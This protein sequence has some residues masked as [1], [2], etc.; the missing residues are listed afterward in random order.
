MNKD[1]SQRDK[2]NDSDERGIKIIR[3]CPLCNVE[4][5]MQDMSVLKRN[6]HAN[7]VH[8]T[9]PE[10]NNSVLSV[11]LITE[12]GLSSIGMVTDLSADDVIKFSKFGPVTEEELLDFHTFMRKKFCRLFDKLYKI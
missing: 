12:T 10:C 7:L 9:C 11:V 3:E 5:E 8:S 1:N 6:D 4:Y 2:K